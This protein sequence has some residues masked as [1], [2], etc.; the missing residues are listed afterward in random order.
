MREFTVIDILKIT[1]KIKD[2]YNKL[3]LLEVNNKIDEKFY[4]LQNELKDL[5]YLETI[6]YNELSNEQFQ[7]LYE[8]RMSTHED[9]LIIGSNQL[10]KS[11][12]ELEPEI[13]LFDKDKYLNMIR[14]DSKLQIEETRR[15]N[16]LKSITD[17]SICGVSLFYKNMDLEVASIFVE[18]VNMA[19]YYNLICNLNLPK[20][21]ILLDTKYSNLYTNSTLEKYVINNNLLDSNINIEP[22]LKLSNKYNNNQN[23]IVECNQYYFDVIEDIIN[24][25]AECNIDYDILDLYLLK[26]K[27]YLLTTYKDYQRYVYDEI[28]EVTT[29]NP[30]IYTMKLFGMVQ[31]ICKVKVKTM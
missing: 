16:N 21:K 23:Y 13:I 26:I 9:N 12:L 4:K 10:Y 2:V 29:N 24:D 22:V 5:I 15:N 1:N 20:K 19:V 3:F 18:E 27:A 17:D 14:I 7:K 28:K 8:Y 31:E 25:I 6:M 30:N 11:Y